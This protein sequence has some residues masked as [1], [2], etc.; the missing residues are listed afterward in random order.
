MTKEELIIE[1]NYVFQK[2]SELKNAALR[3][4]DTDYNLTDE[5]FDSIKS[6]YDEARLFT[7]TL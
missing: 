6:I 1:Y 2:I 3:I 5:E 4:L 7:E